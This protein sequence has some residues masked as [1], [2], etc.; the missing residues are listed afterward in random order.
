MKMSLRYHP[1]DD[2][3]MLGDRELHCGDALQVMV[4]G[5]WRKTRMEMDGNNEWYLVGLRDVNMADLPAR[6]SPQELDFVR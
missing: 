3:W 4:N 6:T 2:R 1:D 5:Q